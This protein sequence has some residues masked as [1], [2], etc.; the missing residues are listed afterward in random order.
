MDEHCSLDGLSSDSEVHNGVDGNHQLPAPSAPT[1]LSAAQRGTHLPV[2]K[3]IAN[4]ACKW[5][6]FTI[7]VKRATLKEPLGSLEAVCCLHKRNSR[8]GCK[9][10]IPIK[11]N[12][13]AA[14][15]TALNTAKYWLLQG[16][17]VERQWMH[18]FSTSLSPLPPE[19]DIAAGILTSMPV[20]WSVQADDEFYMQSATQPKRRKVK[21]G[22]GAAESTE[23]Q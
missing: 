1:I 5:G 8:T 23:A 12:T 19:A 16:A 3:D 14:R 6:I 4:L 15:A 21:A 20:G 13:P 7:S 9:K 17:K 2:P 11:E 18:M 22:I 10:I